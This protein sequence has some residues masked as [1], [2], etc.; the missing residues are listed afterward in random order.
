MSFFPLD[1]VLKKSHGFLLEDCF[2]GRNREALHLP[3]V[4]LP[5]AA[6]G[7]FEDCF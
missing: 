4:I 6:F 5:E 2:S 3:A 7:T 1:P